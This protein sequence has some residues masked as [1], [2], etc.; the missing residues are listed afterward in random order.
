[1]EILVW[2]WVPEAAVRSFLEMVRVVKPLRGMVGVVVGQA[3]AVV[4]LLVTGMVVML[5]P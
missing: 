1:M 4:V 5:V 2:P 3:V